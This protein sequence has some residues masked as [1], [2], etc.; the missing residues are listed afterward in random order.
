M[1][2]HFKSIPVDGSFGWSE[3]EFTIWRNGEVPSWG[4][5]TG[6]IAVCVHAH[7]LNSKV[8][9]VPDHYFLLHLAQN[10]YVALALSLPPSLICR[11]PTNNSSM[12]SVGSCTS[13]S[14]LHHNYQHYES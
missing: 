8:C 4:C 11:N 5:K 2:F 10:C 9:E 13:L 1:G 12:A 14:L 6:K 7:A 3:T